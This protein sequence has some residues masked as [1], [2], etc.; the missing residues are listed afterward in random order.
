MDHAI[1]LG[2]I[3]EQGELGYNFQ[4]QMFQVWYANVEHNYS[5]I[6]RHWSL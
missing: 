3:S 5:V 6:V 4:V 2:E 1:P